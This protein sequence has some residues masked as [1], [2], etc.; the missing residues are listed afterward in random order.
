M[1]WKEIY[2]QNVIMES[3]V[4]AHEKETYIRVDMLN[5]DTSPY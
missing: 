2:I 1:R 3:G 4:R 5:C